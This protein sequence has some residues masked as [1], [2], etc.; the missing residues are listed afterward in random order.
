MENKLD[1]IEDIQK[2]AAEILDY[3]ATNHPQ[4]HI[5]IPIQAMLVASLNGA[6][7][8]EKVSIKQR[9]EAVEE[10]QKAFF[11]YKKSALEFLD[12]EEKQKEWDH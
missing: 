1:S 2:L 4:M 9:R 7:S 5:S 8:C 6:V 11:H 10:V 3:L 12:D